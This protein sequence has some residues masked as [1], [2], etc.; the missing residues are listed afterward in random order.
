M[1][2]KEIDIIVVDDHNIFLDGLTALLKEIDHVNLK[3]TFTN[4]HEALNHIRH[5]N[6]DIVITDIDMPV[7]DGIELSK[8][9]KATSKECKIIVLTMHNNSRAITKLLD[10]GAEGYILKNTGKRE[11]IKA[12]DA[13]ISGHS[14]FS[15][16]VKATYMESRIKG[17]K[18]ASNAVQHKLSKREI[19]IVK[20][21]S[22]ELTTNE[23]AEK[24]F[25]SESTVE[26]HRRNILNK[27]NV[28]NTAGLIKLAIQNNLIE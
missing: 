23:I 9:I 24:L 8:I 16:E 14:Y 7:M 5:H 17:K 11:L 28:R 22:E 10:I 15:E 20:L 26:T 21:I 27:L 6:T 4:G 1:T 12:L 2:R 3:G 18:A 25:I 19:E 13:V